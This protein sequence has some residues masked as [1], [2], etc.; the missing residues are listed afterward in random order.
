MNRIQVVVVCCDFFVSPPKGLL[1]SNCDATK[2][3]WQFH[4]RIPSF[5]LKILNSYSQMVGTQLLLSQPSRRSLHQYQLSTSVRRSMTEATQHLHAV[6][7][8]NTTL[9]VGLTHCTYTLAAFE[10]HKST[11]KKKDLGTQHFGCPI[12]VQVLV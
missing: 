5:H 10:R 6:L 11:K 4:V 8:T 2:K 12:G 7:R 1:N 9:V 3:G